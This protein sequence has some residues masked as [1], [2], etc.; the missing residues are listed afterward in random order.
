LDN[1]FSEYDKYLTDDEGNVS[2]QKKPAPQK[3][4]KAAPA[5]A[6]ADTQMDNNEP[7]K[8]I[9]KTNKASADKNQKIGLSILCGITGVLEVACVIMLAMLDVLPTSILILGIVACILLL[10]IIC[11]LMFMP[12]KHKFGKRKILAT[13]LAA[14]TIISCVIGIYFMSGILGVFDSM[15]SNKKLTKEQLDDPFIMY[16][17]GSDTRS[18]T[19]DDGNS[20]SDVN[21]LA[22]VNPETHQVLLLNTP[23]DYYVPNPA[24]NNGMDKLTHC[25]IYGIDNS[26]KALE[27]LYDI[28]I[29]YECRINF[30]GFE[31]LIDSIG[32]IDVVSDVAFTTE[33]TSNVHIDKGTNHLNGFEALA[34]ARERHALASGD[35]ARGENQMKVIKAIV[36]KVTSSDT[37]IRNYSDIMKS[38]SGMFETDIPQMLMT[39]TVKNQLSDNTDWNIQS[40]AV[41]GG[42]GMAIC[43]SSGESLSVVYQDEKMVNTA[44]DYIQ[45]VVNGEVI[46]TS[47]TAQ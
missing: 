24:L 26:I 16:I 15:G 11:T 19:L 47:A 46:D 42:L 32:G 6:K 18:D 2:F 43:A 20:R 4:N 7:N 41:T 21:I 17:S 14:I 37:I 35:F 9:K 13:V 28:N 44:K 8:K 39:E 33:S 22:V 27:G 23:R 29:N 45:K 25:G 38:L 40:Y 34:F 30:T 36:T 3:S 10:T 5:H 31:T 12:S 1:K